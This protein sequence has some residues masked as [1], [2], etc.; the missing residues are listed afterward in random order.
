MHI[1]QE[2]LNVAHKYFALSEHFAGNYI[3]KTKIYTQALA[4]LKMII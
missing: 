2:K 3:A 1:F 4:S